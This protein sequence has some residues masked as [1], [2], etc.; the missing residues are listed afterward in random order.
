MSYV[1]MYIY[2]ICIYIYICMCVFVSRIHI[3]FGNILRPPSDDRERGLE[4]G[5][6]GRLA[7]PA[8]AI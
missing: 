8:R 1:Y 2:M 3:H 4:R 6:R 7:Q 5:R